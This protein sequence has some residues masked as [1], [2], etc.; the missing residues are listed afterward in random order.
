MIE[1]LFTLPL[2]KILHFQNTGS[3]VKAEIT[4]PVS[5]PYNS[6]EFNS[7]V[8]TIHSERVSDSVFIP[9]EVTKE[10]EGEYKCRVYNEETSI[11]RT[12]ELVTIL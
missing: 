9:H 5:L 7:M 1:I 12:I 10:L 11:E 8:N 2:H 4:P 6:T 3:N